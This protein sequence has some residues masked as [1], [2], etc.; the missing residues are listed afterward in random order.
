ML[1]RGLKRLKDLLIALVTVQIHDHL[2][3]PRNQTAKHL[4]LHGREIKEAVKHQQL[5]LLK[6]GQRNFGALEFAPQNLQR[7]QL[8]G[9]FVRQP[10][11]IQRRSIGGINE[12]DFAIVIE[13]GC[14]LRLAA[15]DLRLEIV[16]ACF[17]NCREVCRRLSGALNFANQRGDGIHAAV[18]VGERFYGLEL[19][20]EAQLLNDLRNQTSA[21]WQLFAIDRNACQK[22]ARKQGLDCRSCPP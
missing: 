11:P 6:P 19:S 20:R 22:P 13:L 15:C 8:V 21:Q 5:N 17:D 9:I 3:D 1:N 16:R 7:A 10:S 2:R 4:A 18:A 12:S 14:G